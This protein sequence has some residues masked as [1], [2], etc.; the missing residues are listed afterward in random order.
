MP[1]ARYIAGC[2]LVVAVTMLQGCW[3][4]ERQFTLLGEGGCRTT[5]GGDG[6]PVYFAGLSSEQCQAQCSAENGGCTA[7]EYNSTNSLCEIH[8]QAIVKVEGVDGVFCHLRN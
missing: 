2:V 8:E 7:F 5:E 6:N 3:D 4:D 1:D